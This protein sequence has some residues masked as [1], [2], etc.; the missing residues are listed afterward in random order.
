MKIGELGDYLAASIIAVC[1]IVKVPCLI[2][3][4]CYGI[5]WLVD[6]TGNS[7]RFP[8][9]IVEFCI[10]A[11]LTAWLYVKE[12]KGLLKNLL[13]PVAAIWFGIFR[14]L[15]DFMRGNPKEM[16]L[17][18]L[19]LPGGRFWSLVVA[20]MGIVMLFFS[21]R[22]YYATASPLRGMI[23]AIVGMAPTKVENQES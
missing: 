12:K 21:I 6:S 10:W 14:F 15:V 3:G 13:W 9:Q 8:S 17:V 1:S 11:M 4:C 20:L 16:Q 19:G 18:I 7:V 23:K 2:N 22:K 5:E